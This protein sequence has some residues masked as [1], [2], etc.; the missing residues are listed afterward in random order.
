[1]T[2]GITD[3]LRYKTRSSDSSDCLHFQFS[4]PQISY[5]QVNNVTGFVVLS[6]TPKS[7]PL[8]VTL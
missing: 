7:K 8:G 6:V 5:G 2:L 4:I 3:T 1:M